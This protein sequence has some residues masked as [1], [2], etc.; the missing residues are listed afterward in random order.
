M[1]LHPV[2]INGDT[3]PHYYV[4]SNGNPWSSKRGDGNAYMLSP[5]INSRGY[6][7]VNI[8]HNGK[9]KS[10]QLHRLVAETLIPFPKP[11]G[12][13]HSDWK[14][15]P[16]SVKRLLVSQYMVNHIDHDKENYHPD[17]LE[18]VTSKGNAVA[19]E[20]HYRNVNG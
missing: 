1:K 12:V 2:I 8:C 6:Y 13:T 18:W 4:D 17:N 20:T 14:T 5:G 7:T 11:E 9:K 10:H 15:T 16:E 19:R 3:V